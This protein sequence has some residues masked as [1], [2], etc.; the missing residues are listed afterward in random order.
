MAEEST[1]VVW[2]PDVHRHYGESLCF[3]YL[4]V[5]YYDDEV[6]KQIMAVL[7]DLKLAGY[8]Y[9]DVF[10]SVDVLLRVWVRTSTR[11]SLLTKLRELPY[12]TVRSVFLCTEPP[13][14]LWWKEYRSELTLK[15]IIPHEAETLTK[16]QAGDFR[17]EST[18]I[19]K[20]SGA[21]SI[22]EVAKSDAIKFFVT[23]TFHGGVPRKGVHLREAVEKADYID[24]KSIYSGPR[25]E[26]IVKGTTPSFYEVG[27]FV[28]HVLRELSPLECSTE[29]HLVAVPPWREKDDVDFLGGSLSPELEQMCK[30]WK[31]DVGRVRSLPRPKQRALADVFEKVCHTELVNLDG[32]S[33][34]PSV[35][36]ALINQ[37]E[38]AAA[39]KFNFLLQLERWC[40]AGIIPPIMRKVYGEDWRKEALPRLRKETGIPHEWTE[41]TWTLVDSISLMGKVYAEHPEENV[42]G[43][44][45]EA[46]MRRAAEWR[47]AFAHGK[48]AKRLED[49]AQVFDFLVAILPIYYRMRTVVNGG[50]LKS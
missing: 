3:I 25:A 31:I 27:R 48:I 43:G 47:N 19:L 49:W 39:E 33:I 37:D 32:R 11:D 15:E 23:I 26:Y 17:H 34:L 45:W 20:K 5:R 16:V 35:T 36:T 21:V 10:G 6:R 44:N 9:Y 18:D 41:D 8:C 50:E 1:L 14:Y 13:Q 24:E 7:A 40:F 38:E 46:V 2:H 4:N 28:L 29:T 22:R 30:M 12:V 42:F